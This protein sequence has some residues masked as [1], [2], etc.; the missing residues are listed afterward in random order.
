MRNVIIRG[1]TYH[2][3]RVIPADCMKVIG[4]KEITQSLKTT[5]RKAAEVIAEE[6][7]SIW[8]KKIERARRKGTP[9]KKLSAID[10]KPQ[11]TDAKVEV[12]RQKLMGLMKKNLPVIF[13]ESDEN[14]LQELL[15]LYESRIKLFKNPEKQTGLSLPELQL[16][17]PWVPCKNKREERLKRQAA[18]EVLELMIIQTRA[19][20]GEVLCQEHDSQDLA[21]S[22]KK[23]SKAPQTVQVSQPS[24]PH[25]EHSQDTG[26]TAIC[27][28]M[29]SS[30]GRVKR[31]EDTIRADV[32]TLKEW[33]HGK[34]DI[35]AYTKKDLVDYVKNCLPYIPKHLSKQK[36]YAGKTIRQCVEMTKKNPEEFP[37]I[38][39]TTAKNRLISLRTLFN[40]AKEQMGLI[41]VN[42]ARGIDVPMTV[43]N[44]KKKRGFTELELKKMWPAIQSVHQENKDT[45]SFYWVPLLSLYHG[46]R[47]NEVASLFL[48]DIYEDEDGVWVIDVNEDGPDKSVKNK[49][50]LRVVPIHPFVS[51]TL[52]F[53]GYVA[54]QKEAN[55][56]GQLF[57]ELSYSEGHG[58]GRR[59]S[60]WFKQWKKGWLAEDSRHKHFHDFRHTFIQTAQNKAKIPDRHSQEITGHSIE[61]V[62]AVHLGY[63][64]KLKPA[65]LL[66]ELQKL[67]YGWE[68][69][70][71][72]DPPKAPPPAAK[73]QKKKRSALSARKK[74]RSAKKNDT[75]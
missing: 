3:R 33:C 34:E 40:Y 64:G 66:E 37:P 41:I 30:K 18:I 63:S 74:K 43:K 70:P 5:D 45:P 51:D 75:I 48:K 54:A 65:D 62:S 71:L 69:E 39:H 16:E 68:D 50:S 47:L 24:Q 13:E 17:G 12:F 44:K 60:Y 67:R 19:E 21:K 35:T 9:P 38:A 31:G 61:G 11:T 72:P 14:D 20:M 25:S 10:H 29:L 58:Y 26:I 6:L 27:E 8:D 1:K 73:V 32:R 59:V 28:L 22:K 2:F 46:F 36:S 52:D 7:N 42:P 23:A 55:P 49:C 4:K 53:K 57:P 56:D 15:N